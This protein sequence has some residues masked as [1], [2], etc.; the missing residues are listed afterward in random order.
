MTEL[1]TRDGY[2][3]GLLKLGAK[4]KNIV[5]LTADLAES[6]RAHWFQEKYPE[7]FFDVGVAEQ[8]MITIAAGM[9][10]MGKIPYASSYATFSPGRN[11]EQI[12]TTICYN[13][14]PVKIAG[15][16]AG[17]SV[18]PDGATHQATEDIAMM[19]ALPN[20]TVIVPCDAIEA[21]KATIAAEKTGPTYLRFGREK[22]PL[23]TNNKTPF[24]IGKSLT[25]KEGNDVAI[26]ACGIVVCEA[27]KAAE[28]LQK[29][30]I[31]AMV[32][33][34]PSIKPLDKKTILKAAKNAGAIVTVEEHQIIGGL[35]SA[36]A[37]FLSE[38]YTVPIIRVGINDR[39]GESGKPEELMAKYGLNAIHIEKAAAKAI[40][41]KARTQE[42]STEYRN[43][44]SQVQP[45]HAFHF[46]TGQVARSIPEMAETLEKIPQEEFSHH[47]NEHKNDIC[48][49]V[50]DIYDDEILTH[51]LT[52]HTTKEEMTEI[53]KMRVAFLQRKVW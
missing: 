39:F 3:K 36:V 1:P 13:N 45:E 47:V 34:S 38:N 14:V 35:G 27:I 16:H 44:L 10:A 7:R 42:L 29:S 5:V 49:W 17:V 19:R 25:M 26:I 28:A 32:I 6:T 43:I 41:T 30:N 24:T 22:T 23:I 11:W 50:K 52:V 21:E 37:E 51:L 46:K 31:N 2:G 20:M 4:N 40:M 12:R 53:L 15:C 9:A 8:N 18:G 33:N 48:Q